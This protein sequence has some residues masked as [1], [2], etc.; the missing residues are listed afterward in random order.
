VADAEMVVIVEG[1]DDFDEVRSS[2]LKLTEQAT[3]D[4]DAAERKESRRC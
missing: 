4:I 1:F 3:R 2:V